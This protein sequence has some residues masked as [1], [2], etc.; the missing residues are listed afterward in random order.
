M[1]EVDLLLDLSKFAIFEHV[2]IEH[3]IDQVE[4]QLRGVLDDVGHSY[5]LGLALQVD[6]EGFDLRHDRIDGCPHLV[7]HRRRDHLL[8]M[9][10]VFLEL[11]LEIVCPIS[12]NYH[13]AR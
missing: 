10:L 4:Q 2:D 13:R 5:S 12:K 11:E 6:L 7:A 1:L 9:T 3:V 8:Q